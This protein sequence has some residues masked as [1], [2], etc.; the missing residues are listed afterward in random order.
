MSDESRS[1]AVGECQET[2]RTLS[3][4]T[5]RSLPPFTPSIFG[6]LPESMALAGIVAELYEAIA[7]DVGEAASRLD[8]IG[9]ALG[10]GH[11][12]GDQPN[13]A[14]PQPE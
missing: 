3:D 9:H 1:K 14:R 11:E 2:A 7:Q 8:E 10:S 13:D 5:A 12:E 6:E 4:L